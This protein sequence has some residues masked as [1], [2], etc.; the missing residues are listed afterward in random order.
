MPKAKHSQHGPLCQAQGRQMSDFSLFNS[1]LTLDLVSHVLSSLCH[2]LSF[3]F[4][5][6][7]L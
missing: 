6:G 4:G 2:F 7:F 1:D 3:M 5:K